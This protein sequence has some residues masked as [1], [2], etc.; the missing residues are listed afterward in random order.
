MVKINNKIA[1]AI[2]CRFLDEIHLQFWQKFSFI[3][4]DSYDIYFVI[5]DENCKVSEHI[6]STYPNINLILLKEKEVLNCGYRKSCY[7]TI[8]RKEVTSWDKAF[9]YFLELNRYK[10]LWLLEDDVFVPSLHTIPNIDKKHIDADLVCPAL[11]I[12]EHRWNISDWPHAWREAWD[13]KIS[14]TWAR[15]L[16]ATVRISFDLQEKILESIGT[17]DKI[18]FIE[19]I[20]PT[21]AVKN[22]LKIESP[23][24]LKNNL[25][26][27]EI[28]DRKGWKKADLNKDNILHPVKV[29][30]Y[31]SLFREILNLNE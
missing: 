17:Y 27:W 3:Y 31:H 6:S 2:L 9:Y 30:P 15:C 23:V 4:K 26:F 24:E 7:Q 10:Y 21:L 18:L 13:F 19:L 16:A 12:V 1:I 28:K 20:I 14:L 29:T 5:D 11:T 22:S 8:K 25:A